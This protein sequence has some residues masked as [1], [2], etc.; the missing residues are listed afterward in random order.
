[1]CV[2]NQLKLMNSS[3]VKGLKAVQDSIESLSS[4]IFELS[5]TKSNTPQSAK[6]VANEEPFEVV[7][8]NTKRTGSQ[9]P[10]EMKQNHFG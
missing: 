8:I 1:M 7:F 10:L 6:S 5:K 4:D 9:Y 3:F 2:V